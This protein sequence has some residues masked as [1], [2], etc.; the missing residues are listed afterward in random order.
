MF[1][2]FSW[3][4]ISI[5]VFSPTSFGRF[6]LSQ[7]NP[8]APSS[9]DEE[10]AIK[11]AKVKRIYVESFGEDVISKQAQAMVIDSL[12]KMHRFIVTEKKENADAILKGVGL[13]KSSQEL[14]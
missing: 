6:K 9:A 11:L 1:K 10:V 5:F 13:E 8:A 7:Q 14:H 2:G 12:T 3:L 4:A